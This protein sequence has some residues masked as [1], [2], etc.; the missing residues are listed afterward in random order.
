MTTR[1]SHLSSSL[2]HE[3]FDQ[4][5]VNKKISGTQKWASEQRTGRCQGHRGKGRRSSHERSPVACVSEVRCHL[6]RPDASWGCHMNQR[7]SDPVKSFITASVGGDGPVDWSHNFLAS[8]NAEDDSILQYLVI[9]LI[10]P[11]YNLGFKLQ[12]G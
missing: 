12:E 9:N 1:V 2:D 10:Y 11:T 7:P 4:L 5:C 6:Q 3:N 8:F